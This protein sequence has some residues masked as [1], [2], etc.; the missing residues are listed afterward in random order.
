MALLVIGGVGLAVGALQGCAVVGHDTY[1]GAKFM[2][3]RQ[4]SDFDTPNLESADVQTAC[5]SA[6]SRLLA[7][8]LLNR[9]SRTP[10]FVV[11]DDHF[12]NE[13]QGDFDTRTLVDLFRNELV[14]AGQ[15]RLRVVHPA[16]EDTPVSADFIVEGR[17][18]DVWNTQRRVAE[19]YTQ[20]AFNVVL[21]GSGEV[22]FSD[23]YS[24][25][26]GASIAASL[27]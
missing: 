25:K 17:V 1:Q 23:V 6:V 5:A 8:D 3:V 22:V 16:A 20:I 12:E 18:T 19:A 24:V 10:V 27:Y 11:E 9:V 4:P 21:A 7:S 14:N 26:K 13:G 15:G 2:D